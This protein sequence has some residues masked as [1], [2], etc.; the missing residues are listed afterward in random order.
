LLLLLLMLM[1]LVVVVGLL[2]LLLL[3]RLRVL[4]LLLLLLMLPLPLPL[5]LPLL[6]PLPLLPL[7][8]LLPL[9]S[10]SLMSAP[11]C[12]SAKKAHG[13]P[14]VGHVPAFVSTSPHSSIHPAVATSTSLA[15]LLRIFSVMVEGSR[16]RFCGSPSSPSLASIGSM[17]PCSFACTRE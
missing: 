13:Q 3:G 15:I 11:H 2:L 12:R 4:L 7:L 16:S 9:P 1:L 10:P 5:L 6:L 8:L 14:W 17:S